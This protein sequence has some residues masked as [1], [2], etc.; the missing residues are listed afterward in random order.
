MDTIIINYP[1]RE[2]KIKKKKTYKYL[3]DTIRRNNICI[4]GFP[5]E[6][7]KEKRAESLFKEIMTEIFPNL[8][9]KMYIKPKEFYIN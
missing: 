7:E 2:T 6:A 9:R 8:G 1:F 3:W 5:E 4:M